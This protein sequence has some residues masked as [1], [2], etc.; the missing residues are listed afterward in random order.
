MCWKSDKIPV[1]HIATDNIICY[2]VFSKLDI[3]WKIKKTSDSSFENKIEKVKSYYENYV[4]IPYNVN[5]KVNIVYEFD[6]AWS[7]DWF[8]CEGYHSF[9]S[10]DL[11]KKYRKSYFC[12]LECIIP[13]DS[14]YYINESNEIVSSNIIITDKIVG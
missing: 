5:P 11:P 2:K 13:K 7:G 14:E 12:V 6:N 9:K 3:I 10:L 1:K 4:Y 8:I